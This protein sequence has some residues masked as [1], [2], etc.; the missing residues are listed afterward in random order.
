MKEID[1]IGG[2]RAL[3]KLDLSFN[4]LTSYSGLKQVYNLTWLNI[5]NNQIVEMENLELLSNLSYLSLA[6][7]KVCYAV[8]LD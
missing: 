6:C 8:I 3:R 5:S 4:L 2:C 1:D 7:N